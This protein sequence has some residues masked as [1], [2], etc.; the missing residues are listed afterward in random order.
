[1]GLDKSTLKSD[2]E[3]LMTSAKDQQ[4]TVSQVAQAMADAVDRFVRGADV[5]QVTVSIGGTTHHQDNK[6]KLQ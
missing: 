4:W 5:V 1:M 2:L 3:T 6:G